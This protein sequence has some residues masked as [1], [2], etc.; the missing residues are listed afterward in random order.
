[1]LDN[2][3]NLQS[4]WVTMGIKVGQMALRFGANDFGSLMMEEN[5][6]SAAGTTYRTTIARDRAPHPRRRA[7]SPRGAGRTTRSSRRP[8]RGVTRVRVGIGYDSHRFV[9]GPPADPRRRHA[10][11]IRDGPRRAIRMPTRWRTRSPT[12]SSA[13]PAPATSAQLFPDTDPQWK[14]ADSHGAAADRARA[15]ASVGATR[16]RRRTDSVII[17]RPQLGAA[18]RRRWPPRSR[19]G[20]GVAAGAVSVKAKTNEGMGFIGR[21]EGLAVIAVAVLEAR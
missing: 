1:M 6:V 10:F 5:V 20:C 21:G 12:R 15:G 16:W 3:P 9:A 14:D 17:E 7:T 18:P 2:V 19:R 8:V 13:P 11:R 4:R